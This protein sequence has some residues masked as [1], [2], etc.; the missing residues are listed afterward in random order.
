[1]PFTLAHPAAVV[2]L[3]RYLPLSALVVGSLSPDFEYPFRLAA[4]SRFSHTLP[5][6]LYFCVPVGLLFLWLFH[7]LIKRPV[8]LL[9]PSLVR[10]RAEPFAER[11]NFWPAS[12][13]LL[14]LISIFTGAFTHVAWDAFTHEYGWVVERWPLLQASVISVAGHEL[15]LFK[16]LQYGS[17][18]AG[19]LLLVYFFMRWLRDRPDDTSQAASLPEPVRRRA[20]ALIILL[21]VAGSVATGLWPASELRGLQR[22]QVFVVQSAIGGM[23]SLACCLFLYSLL[24]QAMLPESDIKRGLQTVNRSS[25]K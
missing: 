10:R 19:I 5:G 17:S 8:I 2:P 6:I 24:I 11:F 15:R 7:R 1:M 21:T 25:L 9:L 12:R 3:R 22:M 14:I 23:L 16:L 20:V 18:L 13:L 4:V